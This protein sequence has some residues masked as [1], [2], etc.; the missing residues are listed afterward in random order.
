MC[1]VRDCFF[2][3]DAGENATRF[4]VIARVEKLG[5]FRAPTTC[6]NAI[7]A[8]LHIRKISLLLVP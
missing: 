2:V 7:V 3:C 1:C 6:K 5:L 8:L 4:L